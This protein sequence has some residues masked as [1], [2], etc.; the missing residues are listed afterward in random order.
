MRKKR[1]IIN[2]KKLLSNRENKNLK[3]MYCHNKAAFTLV[4]VV[5]S[6]GVCSLAI[7]LISG[8][9]LLMQKQTIQTTLDDQIQWQQMIELFHGADLELM[10]QEKITG[11]NLKFYSPKQDRT[12]IFVYRSKKIYMED[13]RSGGY[14]PVLYDVSAWNMSY[15]EPYLKI[16]ATMHDKEYQETLYLQRKEVET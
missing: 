2:L 12:Y 13:S 9:L 16:T 4:E 7:L 6:L 10:Y 8:L 3:S 15:Q 1:Q 11:G 14:M 5:I